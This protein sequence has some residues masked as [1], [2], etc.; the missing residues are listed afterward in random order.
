MTLECNLFD[1]LWLF[2]G[3]YCFDLLSLTI[4]LSITRVY[5]VQIKGHI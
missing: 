5:L 1:T 3:K 2:Y 4:E